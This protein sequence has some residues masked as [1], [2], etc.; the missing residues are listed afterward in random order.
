MASKELALRDRGVLARAT[1]APGHALKALNRMLFQ[2][3]AG[4]TRWFTPRGR[5]DYR[6][7][8]G[9]G[10]TSSVIM[11]CVLWMARTFPEAPMQV[12]DSEGAEIERHP[13][14]KLLKRPNAFYS[15]KAMWWGL[16]LSLVLDGNGYLIK[17]RNRVGGVLELWY[18]P[19]WMIEP[20]S[21]DPAVF[22]EYYRYT[23][24]NQVI[25]LEV[26]DVVHLRYGLDPRDTRKGLSPLG[27]VL[28]EVFTDDEA[29]QFSA[30]ILRNMGVPGVVVSPDPQAPPMGV[31]DAEAIREHIK[32]MTG[33]RRGEPLILPG[34][35]KVSQFGFNPQQM[36]LKTLRR[37][38]EE[39][40]SAV[41][42]T[43]AIVVGLGAGLDRSTFANFSEA[44][45]AAYESNIIPLHGLVADDIHTQ[46]LGDFE[47]DIDLFEVAHDYSKVRVLQED[48]VKAANVHAILFKAGL[49]TRAKVLADIGEE[50]TPA[51]EVY[52]IPGGV[53]LVPVGEMPAPPPEPEP[54]DN[55]S[56]SGEDDPPEPEPEPPA[57]RLKVKA[58]T[59]EQTE[60]MRQVLT[61]Q[62][63]IG[64][65]LATVFAEEIEQDLETLGDLAAA[66]FL[67]TQEE[68]VTLA[69]RAA[70]PSL[71]AAEDEDAEIASIARAVVD[72]VN[73]ARVAVTTWKDRFVE[74]YRRAAQ[75]TVK[76]IGRV[77]GV[78]VMLPSSAELTV[79]DQG[80][81]RAGLV[82][83]D[84]QSREAVAKAIREGREQNLGASEIAKLVKEHV[85][86]G[87]FV[88]AGVK[89]RA[90][91]IARTETKFAQNLSS[92]Q[93]YRASPV[94]SAV[95][96]FDAQG[97]GESDA[98]CIARNGKQF[99][100]DEAEL[101]MALEHPN[102]T[103]AW[104]PVTSL[105]LFAD[106]F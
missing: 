27:T 24:D 35:T 79:I 20:V 72:A 106:A 44:R 16:I 1:R 90:S 46:L 18:V 73:V 40:V 21:D 62:E 67:N 14:V 12:L 8:V 61:R 64:R 48:R 9:D 13:M 70:R 50:S 6:R 28:R 81:K 45:E 56:G 77:S 34:A 78:T 4:V 100:F 66:A 69:A 68:G 105:D 102:G 93:T 49:I 11:A 60:E 52:M 65:A 59:G 86:A 89:Y 38:P 55:G 80:T 39:R 96:A 75:E 30:S 58:P 31:Q 23:P 43:P 95:V 17:V 2:R 26:E 36:E 25:R 83:L 53:T 10:M 103:L 71:K 29:A 63:A 94:V 98:D 87:R 37:L 74:H 32:G 47:D 84:T 76:A 101:E 104:G 88:H 33:S 22:I 41:L 91:L 85:T 42:G 19:H 57:K 15:G 5:I 82:D 7:E 97:K 54:P 51:D 99:S 3:G 92:L